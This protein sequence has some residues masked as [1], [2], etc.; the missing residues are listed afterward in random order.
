MPQ[1]DWI[2]IDPARRDG[3]G[4]KV[5]A[6]ADCTPNVVALK[7]SLLSKSPRIMIKC[8]PMLDVTAACNE[9]QSV[10]EIH[11]VATN[12]ECKELLFIVERE[13]RESPATHCVN[14]TK[15]GT[16]RFTFTAD[17]EATATV[18]YTSEIGGYLYEPNA[19]IQKGGC[20]RRLAQAT[21]TRKLHPNSHLYTSDELVKEFPGRTFKVE[22]MLGFTKSDIKRVSELKK[23]NITTRNHPDS[24]Q[25]L[26]K[27]LK[28]ADGGDKYIFATTLADGHRALILCS[29]AQ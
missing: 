23:A 8:S 14:I 24:V 9:L 5:V 27:R 3:N 2:F 26:R 18:T 6:L 21:G 16:E 11:I 15:G 12:N 13:R 1:N 20:Y 4:R 25:A 10:T 7:E 19:A 28:L 22:E 17:E 29:K